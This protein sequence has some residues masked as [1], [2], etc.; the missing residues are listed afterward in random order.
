MI[1]GID[2]NEVVR[3]FVGQFLYVY[4]RYYNTV[5]VEISDIK[6]LDFTQPPFSF[7]N[8]DE[9]NHHLYVESSL[10]IFGHAS[11]LDDKIISKLNFLNVELK[12]LTSHKLKIVS[13]EIN[14]S[15][16]STLFFLSKFSCTI[17][18]YE[19]VRNYNDSWNNVD[20]L[21]TACPNTL[22]SKPEGKISVKVKSSY[23]D[24]ANSDYTIGSLLEFIYDEELRNNI[25]N[26]KIVS[27]KEIK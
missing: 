14:K 7:E 5:D 26:N 15:I 16:P 18:E 22:N 9:V 10:P 27:F 8:I 13:R 21:I 24:E 2:L 25:L 20:I 1:I 3:D 17:D 12:D 11:E 19:F 6:T 4:E 23:N